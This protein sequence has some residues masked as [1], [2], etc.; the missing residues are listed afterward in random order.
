MANK[1]VKHCWYT[2]TTTLL[3]YLG[4]YMMI[5]LLTKLSINVPYSNKEIK[6]EIY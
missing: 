6:D 1:G 3:Q 4:L 2:Q 5:P